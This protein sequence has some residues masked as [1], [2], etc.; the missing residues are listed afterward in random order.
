MSEKIITLSVPIQHGT[1]TLSELSLRKPLARDLRGF[2]W[3]ELTKFNVLEELLAKLSGL[4]L[5]VIGTL[6]CADYFACLKV[7]NDFLLSSPETGVS[8]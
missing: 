6:D 1:Q 8:A 7:L 5:S 4:P 2:S 3:Q